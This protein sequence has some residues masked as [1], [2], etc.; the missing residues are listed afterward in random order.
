MHV[1]KKLGENGRTIEAALPLLV[2]ELV[3]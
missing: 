1:L 2:L 3:V